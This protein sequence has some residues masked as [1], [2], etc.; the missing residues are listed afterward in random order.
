MDIRSFI[1][2]AFRTAFKDTWLYR[3]R[4]WSITR[5]EAAEVMTRYMD[6]ESMSVQ[7]RKEILSQMKKAL[8]LDGWQYYEFFMFHYRDISK[9]QRKEFVT[10]FEKDN[11]TRKMTDEELDF[12]GN[13]LSKYST[14]SSPKKPGRGRKKK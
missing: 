2:R 3:W 6:V 8:I 5:N 12:L 10:E 1:S 9:A 11:W 7:Q 14:V 13:L 4:V